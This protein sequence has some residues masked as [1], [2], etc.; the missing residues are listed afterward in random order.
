M[1]T[2]Q[3]YDKQGKAITLV[4]KA[5]KDGL[6]VRPDACEL[7]GEIPKG[8]AQPASKCLIHG[9]HWNGYGNALDVWWVCQ[10]CNFKLA[11]EVFHCG[12]ITKEQAKAIVAMSSEDR[13]AIRNACFRRL[14]TLKFGKLPTYTAY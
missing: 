8:F 12:I 10:S 7:C 3:Q 1:Y 14:R 5:V 4:N 6:L 9:H 11:G 13:V 2:P